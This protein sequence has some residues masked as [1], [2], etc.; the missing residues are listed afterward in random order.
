LP[1]KN[2]EEIMKKTSNITDTIK[3]LR[4]T[5]AREIEFRGKSEYNEEWLYGDLR[6]CNHPNPEAIYIQPFEVVRAYE[7]VPAT[8]GQFTGL[9]DK[10]GVKIFEGDIIKLAKKGKYELWQ[11]MEHLGAFCLVGSELIN[12]GSISSKNL[13]V[14]DNIRDNDR[15]VCKCLRG[16]E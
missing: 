12:A 15:G 10:N 4:E 6:Q 3:T 9:K 8:L 11:V 2:K 16:S 1:K 7:I 13:E 5:I 14:I